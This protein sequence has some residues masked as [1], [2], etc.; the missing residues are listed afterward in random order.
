[1]EGFEWVSDDWG[2]PISPPRLSGQ[3]WLPPRVAGAD[4]AWRNPLTVGDPKAT[5]KRTVAQ[6]KA[7]GVIGLYRAIES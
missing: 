7:M 4:A 5:D 1:M 6:L 2:T 3:P